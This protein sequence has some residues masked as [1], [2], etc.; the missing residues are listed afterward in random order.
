MNELVE[1]IRARLDDRLTLPRL[2]RR[3]EPM[4]QV[5]AAPSADIWT[6]RRVPSWV[7]VTLEEIMRAIHLAK[8]WAGVGSVPATRRA[9]VTALMVLVETMAE[10]SVPPQ[11]VPTF[12]GGLQLEWHCAGVDLEVYVEPDGQ[13]SAWCRDEIHEWEEERYPRARLGKELA[14]LTNASCVKLLAAPYADRD[15]YRQ[16]WAPE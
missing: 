1:W 3:T 4:M 6:Q 14:L 11:V 5:S 8:G 16:E 7:R 13:V 15:G 12:D 10:D 9:V 2:T